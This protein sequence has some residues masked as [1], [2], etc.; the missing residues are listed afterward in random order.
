V[1]IC[2]S[3]VAAGEEVYLQFNYLHNISNIHIPPGSSRD[4]SCEIIAPS[5][6]N[7]VLLTFVH[8]QLRTSKNGGLTQVCSNMTVETTIL[9]K[10]FGCLDNIFQMKTITISSSTEMITLKN[11]PHTYP[12]SEQ[13]LILARSKL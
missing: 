8:A 4:C 10:T 9:N 3:K 11:I 2:S 7:H 13:V 1:D 12:A 6:S 5:C